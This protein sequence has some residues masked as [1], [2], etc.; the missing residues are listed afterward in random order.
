MRDVQGIRETAESECPMET[1]NTYNRVRSYSILRFTA[2]V[3]VVTP[4]GL[5]AAVVLRLYIEPSR[6]IHRVPN[7]QKF[8]VSG[9]KRLGG[10]ANATP[11]GFPNNMIRHGY[12]EAVSVFLEAH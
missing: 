8:Y 4:S 5:D 2:P 3:A 1:L 6:V 10:V 11:V 9:S 7:E 12:S